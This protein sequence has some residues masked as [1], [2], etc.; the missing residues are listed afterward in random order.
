MEDK[1]KSFRE[2]GE[3]FRLAKGTERA[4]EISKMGVETRKERK[5]LRESMQATMDMLLRKSI[6]EGAQIDPE[7]ILSIAETEGKNISVQQAIALAQIQK[8]LLGDTESAKFIRDT[9]GEKPV[10]KIEAQMSI[11]DYVKNHKVKF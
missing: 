6:K 4:K 2:G 8:A 5:M 3:P 10:E 9:L 11:E 7:D 1:W